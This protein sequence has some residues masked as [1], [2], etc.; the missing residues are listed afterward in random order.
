VAIVTGGGSGIGR[1]TA[2]LLAERKASVVVCGRRLEALN[3]TVTLIERSGGRG[4]ALTTDIRDSL[5]V[6]AMVRAVLERF[7]RIDVLINNAG[8]A[9]A[10]P[11]G[12]TTDAEWDE[13]I[14]TNLKGVFLCSK[15]VLPNMIAAGRGVIINVSSILGQ[16]GVR[17]LSAYCAS[18]FGVIGLTQAL[19]DEL[20]PLPIR[21]YAVCPGPTYTDLHRGVVGDERAKLAMP[22]EKVSTKI[23]SLASEDFR[24]PSG[25][26]I[27]IDELP[28]APDLRGVRGKW[29]QVARGC[30]KPVLCVVS[31]I[32]RVLG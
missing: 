13:V 1:T 24:L 29:R 2:L 18:K 12:E 3:E 21:V 8:V 28:P 17:N 14:D 15:A 10:K 30:L 19:A 25:S 11:M 7:G 22:P 23:V 20:Q 5:H 31:K 26:A 27:V 9:L 32:R 16:S 4:I 6:S